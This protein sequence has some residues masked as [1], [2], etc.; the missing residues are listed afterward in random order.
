[1]TY[2]VYRDLCCEFYFG[3]YWSVAIYKQLKSNVTK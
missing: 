1:M 3:L 2:E